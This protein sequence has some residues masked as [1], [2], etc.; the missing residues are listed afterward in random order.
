MLLLHGINHAK[1]LLINMTNS[2]CLQLHFTINKGL[3]LLPTG[4]DLFTYGFIAYCFFCFYNIFI[5]Y[6]GYYISGLHWDHDLKNDGYFAVR[7]SR[8]FSRKCI[9][10]LGK[11]KGIILFTSDIELTAIHPTLEGFTFPSP[12]CSLLTPSHLPGEDT[13]LVES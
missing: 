1:Q 8:N 10:I 3:A 6:I 7:E 5:A 12:A 4:V 13:V 11:S 2:N 9:W